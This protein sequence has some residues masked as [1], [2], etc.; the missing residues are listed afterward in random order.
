MVIDL[1]FLEKAANRKAYLKILKKQE[2]C[3][4]KN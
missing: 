2:R 1:C 4:G 3:N